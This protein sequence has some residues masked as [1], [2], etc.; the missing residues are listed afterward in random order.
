MNKLKELEIREVS[1]TAAGKNPVAY[2]TLFKAKEE[3]NMEEKKTL[4][5]NTVE[6]SAPVIE[7]EIGN[8]MDAAANLDAVT[9][10]ETLVKSLAARLD[11][12]ITK[13]EDAEFMAI[14]KKYELLGTPAAEL[15]P[16]LKS[17]KAANPAAYESS[18]KALDVSM[19]ALTKAGIFE[20]IGKSGDGAKPDAQAQIAAAVA[21]IRKSNP[22]ID[23]REAIDMAFRAHPELQY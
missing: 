3:K 9:R 7:S 17:V 8:K 11:E 18:I 20:E 4:E 19:N 16:L 21:E 15:A 13:A 12:Q 10:L 14:A 23:E 2:V 22:T 5:Q 6:K 1:L